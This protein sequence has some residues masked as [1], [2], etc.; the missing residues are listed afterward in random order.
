[1]G[2]GQNRQKNPATENR[3]MAKTMK[4]TNRQATNKQRFEK[5]STVQMKIECN[6][7]ITSPDPMKRMHGGGLLACRMIT[8]KKYE[9]TMSGAAGKSRLMCGFIVD[10]T[11][12]MAKELIN[13]ELVVSFLGLPAYITDE[14]ILLHG[15]GVSAVSAIKQH[16]VAADT[17]GRWT[18]SSQS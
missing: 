13:S 18:Q 8:E 11:Q 7:K 6:D 14:E 9:I 15:W 1:M 3:N 5:D 10:S 16:R 17:S 12:I 2:S 4:E